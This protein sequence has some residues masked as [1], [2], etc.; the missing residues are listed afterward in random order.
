MQTNDKRPESEAPGEI[1][2]VED[3]LEDPSEGQTPRGGPPPITDFYLTGLRTDGRSETPNFYTFL[4]EQEGQLH[5]LIG[6]G[7]VVFFTHL[8]LASDALRSAGIEAQFRRLTLENVYLVDVAMALHLLAHEQADEGK[9][10]A[11]MLD[12]F[13]RILTAL[14]IALPP[15]FEVLI[16]LGRHA[17]ANVYFADFLAEEPFRRE[18]AVDGVRWC[19]GAILSVSRIITNPQGVGG[20]V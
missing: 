1:E 15:V 18:R 9:V 3:L 14:G 8:D 10:I 12:L 5:P 6:D 19:L 2:R 16:D 20:R 13:A 17:D 7:Q 11:N 4:L